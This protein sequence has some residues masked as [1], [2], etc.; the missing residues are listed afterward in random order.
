MTWPSDPS[1]GYS[2]MIIELI[3]TTREL[4]DGSEVELKWKIDTPK[5]AE[6]GL[7]PLKKHP[8]SAVT[9]GCNKFWDALIEKFKNYLSSISPNSS[10]N[11]LGKL[12]ITN[13]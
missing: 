6:I 12:T 5:Y 1:S 3:A 11:Q 9:K 4:K 8:A 10:K 2:T 7:D 13:T